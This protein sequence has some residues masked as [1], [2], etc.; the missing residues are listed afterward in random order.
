MVERSDPTSV[1]KLQWESIATPIVVVTRSSV[2]IRLP[3][4]T[5]ELVVTLPRSASPAVVV[6]R[7]LAAIHAS[8][9]TVILTVTS[10]PT[11]ATCVPVTTLISIATQALA[12]TL[13]P[14]E[15]PVLPMT[16]LSIATHCLLSPD[17]LAVCARPIASLDA[18][19][20]FPRWMLSPDCLVGCSCRIHSLAALESCHIRSRCCLSL[21][22]LAVFSRQ[23]HLPDG[24][25]GLP[26]WMLSPDGLPVVARRFLSLDALTRYAHCLLHTL[27]SLTSLAD[28]TR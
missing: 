18:L 27:H 22:S 20:G 15:S 6:T 1:H 12:S 28:F 8:T 11:T 13:L 4:F 25:A 9:A 23:P 2:S 3:N 26:C 21:L 14:V 5:G 19:A 10:S 24:L 7:S 16:L 17:C